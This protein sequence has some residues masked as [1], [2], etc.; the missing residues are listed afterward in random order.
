MKHVDVA[1]IGAGPNGLSLALHLAKAGLDFQ[2]FGQPMAFWSKVARAAPRRYLKTFCSGTDIAAPDPGM[3]FT[4]WS[5]DRGLETF[6]PCT[7]SDFAD[8]GVWVQ[9]NKLP[10]ID[11][12]SITSVTSVSG[13]YCLRLDQGEH[14]FA[15]RV[16]VAT[17]LSSFEYLPPELATLPPWFSTHSNAVVNYSV[18]RDK[19]VAV[20]GAGQSALEATALLHEAGAFVDLIVR[21]PTIRWMTRL[22]AERGLLQRF[23]RPVSALG[24]GIKSWAFTRFPGASYYLPDH[25][26]ADLLD[27]HIPP[28]GAWWLR[29]RCQKAAATML[30]TRVVGADA[31]DSKVK[32]SLSIDDGPSFERFYDHVIPATGYRV[33]VDQLGLLDQHTRSAIARIDTAPRLDRA[34][35]S[36]APGLY[37]IGPSAAMSFGPLCR[38]VAGAAHAA[39]TVASHLKRALAKKSSLHS[40]AAGQA[41]D[42]GTVVSGKPVP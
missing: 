17:G 37:F 41:V 26:R 30:S 38:F 8:Y 32:L 16:V 33:D 23:R 31:C 39:P 35:Q 5:R 9:Q 11:S 42:R 15:K 19:K 3:C 36:S 1:I 7:I 40:A 12:S 6:E 2:V 34:F 14:H 20:V 18:F 24:V 25:I 21:D 27:R 29:D 28:S 4:D 22:P 10:S 13:G